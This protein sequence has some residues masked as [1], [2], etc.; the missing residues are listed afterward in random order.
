MT[1]KK[2]ILSYVKHE[3]QDGKFSD[4]DPSLSKRLHCNVFLY[5][6][7]QYNY[8]RIDCFSISSKYATKSIYSQYFVIINVMSICL[9]THRNCIFKYLMFSTLAVLQVFKKLLSKLPSCL[10]LETPEIRKITDLLFLNR[11]LPGK[12]GCSEL[13]EMIGFRILGQHDS[14]NL[15]RGRESVC[16][17]KN[18]L[19]N[20][21][22]PRIRR[23]F[24]QLSNKIDFR[25]DSLVTF[26]ISPIP[27]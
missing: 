4:T 25:A 15:Q 9:I 6:F 20:N 2:I 24:N 13:L 8:L 23:L 27:F 7:Y 12:F 3:V 19:E 22:A 17:A 14:L 16:Y 18:Y 26:K 21:P 5:K 10:K 11:I 1:L